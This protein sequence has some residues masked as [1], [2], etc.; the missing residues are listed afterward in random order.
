MRF[1]RDSRHCRAISPIS[2]IYAT[3]AMCTTKKIR[4][5]NLKVQPEVNNQTVP[6]APLSRMWGL[7]QSAGAGPPKIASNPRNHSNNQPT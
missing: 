7:R 5:V 2:S 1:C 4:R 3:N 6:N